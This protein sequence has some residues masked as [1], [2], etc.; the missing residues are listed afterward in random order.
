M[1][2]FVGANFDLVSQL[3]KELEEKEQELENSKPQLAQGEAQHK[4]EIQHLKSEYE[5]NLR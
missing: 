4:Q 5:Q 2:A 1:G 3:N